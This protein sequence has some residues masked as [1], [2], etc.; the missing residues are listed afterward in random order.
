MA[1]ESP[2]GTARRT[3]RRIEGG[4]LEGPLH[5]RRCERIWRHVWVETRPQVI[6]IFCE[7]PTAFPICPG[8]I[9]EP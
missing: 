8:I 7:R 3:T 5:C 2:T 9:G 6:C 4:V 1:E